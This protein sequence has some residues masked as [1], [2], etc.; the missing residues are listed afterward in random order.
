MTNINAL[1]ENVAKEL[2]VL[3]ELL[4]GHPLLIGERSGAGLLEDDVVYDR[5]GIQSISPET[6]KSHLLDGAPLKIYAA[7]GG[8]YVNLDNERLTNLR[9]KQ[10]ISLGSFAR[11]VKV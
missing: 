1:S 7:P 2:I 5:F 11:S 8:F 9:Q 3:S 6:L 4:N 10:Y